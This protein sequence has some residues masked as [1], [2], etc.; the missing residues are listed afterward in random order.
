MSKSRPQVKDKLKEWYDW[1]V[2][3]VSK[4]IKEKASKAFKTFKDKIMGLYERVRGEKEPEDKKNEESSNS[5]EPETRINLIKSQIQ[6]RAYQV[7]S[8]LN[9][10]VSNL[11]LHT[12]CPNI[13][14]RMRVIYSFSCSI[15]RGWNQVVQYYRMLF[16]NG[17]FTSLSQILEYI[18]QCEL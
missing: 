2:N 1:L 5:V 15:Y 7:T 12:I 3:H 10:D 9:H 17:T 6:I 4:P 16:P 18:K 14:M 11:I 8:S 13:K